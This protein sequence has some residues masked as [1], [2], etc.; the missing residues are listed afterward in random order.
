MERHSYLKDSQ[1]VTFDLALV[2]WA[3]RRYR[4]LVFFVVRADHWRSFDSALTDLRAGPLDSYR[5]WLHHRWA[6]V[7]KAPAAAFTSNLR[8]PLANTI[9]R[10]DSDR[11][12]CLPQDVMLTDKL[13]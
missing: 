8:I 7:L 6:H 9:V 3:D 13:D 2:A 4:L 1:D 5:A 11:V 12:H 10:Y